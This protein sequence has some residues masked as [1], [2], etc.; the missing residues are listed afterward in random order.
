MSNPRFVPELAE[1]EYYRRQWDVGLKQRVLRVQL[2]PHTRVFRGTDTAKITRTVRGLRYVQSA[3]RGKQMLF[4]FGRDAWL[5]IHLGMT[6][7]LRVTRAPYKPQKHDHLTIHLQCHVLIY[8]DP[9]QFGRIQF[10]SASAPP[11]IWTRVP[12]PPNH[13]LFTLASVEQFL[14]RHPK[15]PIKATLL[16]QTGF[17]GI[18][19]WM[20]DEILWQTRL[21]PLTLTAHITI[22]Q[23]RNLWKAT[24]VITRAAL[25]TIGRDYSDPPQNWLFHERWSLKGACPKH[26]T[27]LQRATVGGRT[28]AWCPKCQR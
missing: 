22:A 18:G 11:T 24:R 27:P 26:R 8:T 4:Q 25:R 6:G 1:V 28:T 20:A 3:A 16:L 23:A 10:T 13:P 5:A 21:H 14:A 2:H 19:N 17:P 7:K 9:R 15:L 12:P